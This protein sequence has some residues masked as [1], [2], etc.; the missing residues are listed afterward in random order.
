[1]QIKTSLPIFLALLISAMSNTICAQLVLPSADNEKL[2][3]TTIIPAIDKDISYPDLET[4]IL[5]KDVPQDVFSIQKNL[6]YSQYGFM[7]KQEAK[8]DKQTKIPVRMRLGTLDAV[9]QKEY[10]ENY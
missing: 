10:G 1:M 4:L 3:L 7:C 8:R 2:T 9:N 6:V 5:Q